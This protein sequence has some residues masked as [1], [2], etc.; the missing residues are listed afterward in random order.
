[1]RELGTE[2]GSSSGAAGL[3]DLRGC[4]TVNP[5]PGGGAM[6]DTSQRNL[7]R[8]VVGEIFHELGLWERWDQNIEDWYRN[9][10]R[11][12]SS[13]IAERLSDSKQGSHCGAA[14]S[15]ILD[16]DLKKK[17]SPGVSLCECRVCGTAF[18]PC[19]SRK[20]SRAHTA[21]EVREDK[22]RRSLVTS[23]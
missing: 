20:P 21:Q 6:L 23:L 12:L 13:H 10:G 3:S 17:S 11:I 8:E 15:Q 7:Y 22:C 4:V 19:S 18:V 2:P 5:H 9:Q 1:M 14:I 16:H